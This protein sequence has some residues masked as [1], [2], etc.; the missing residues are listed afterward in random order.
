MRFGIISL[1][2]TEGMMQISL[3]LKV[4]PM[5]KIGKPNHI[6]LVMVIWEQIFLKEYKLQIKPFT[7]KVYTLW[8]V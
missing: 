7:I 1:L 3:K 6:Q 2:S 8:E 4:I 5:M